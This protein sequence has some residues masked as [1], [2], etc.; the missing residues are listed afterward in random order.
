ML[1]ILPLEVQELIA[2]YC[3]QADAFRLA[4]TCRR[5]ARASV[6]R[7]YKA[8]VIDSRESYIDSAEIGH[9]TSKHTDK[10]VECNGPETLHSLKTVVRN[11]LALKRCVR[12]LKNT[13]NGM[14]T[15]VRHLECYKL[16]DMTSHEFK[17]HMSAMIPLLPKLQSLVWKCSPQ[18]SLPLMVTCNIGQ[19]MNSLTTI[20][21][22][23]PESLEACLDAMASKLEFP[24]LLHFELRSFTNP[25]NLTTVGRLL[26]RSPKLATLNLG[27]DMVVSRCLC[28]GNMTSSTRIHDHESQRKGALENFIN[29]YRDSAAG[30]KLE[31]CKFGIDGSVVHP[32]DADGLMDIL[33]LDA[34]KSL[35]LVNICE[36]PDDPDSLEIPRGASFLDKM[37]GKTPN[38]T[39]LHIDWSESGL[40]DTVPAYIA[41]FAQHGLESLNVKIRWTEYRIRAQKDEV[42]VTQ[43]QDAAITVSWEQTCRAYLSAIDENASS[44]RKLS[45]ESAEESRFADRAKIIPADILACIKQCR[46]LEGLRVLLKAMLLSDPSMLKDLHR[47]HYLDLFSDGGP[48]FLGQGS[49]V[50]DKRQDWL[51]YR[52]FVCDLL[53]NQPSLSFIKIESAY[54]FDLRSGDT[55]GVIGGADKWFADQVI[56]SWDT[57]TT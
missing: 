26:A 22:E 13:D 39:S 28:F 2:E 36:R 7:L 1:A 27:R 52:H 29:A 14:Y 51:R 15:L 10:T 33:V 30:K 50:G 32:K 44:L 31:L 49:F 4:L 57:V 56:D 41:S 34:L 8:I 20:S 48:S 19:C 12:S 45:L 42:H 17:K 6:P 11:A 16:P 18:V 25:E 43:S 37:A 38:V 5:L 21:L 54:L 47:L 9:I 23:I 35:S 53:D 24:N 3:Q 40:R 55:W 46:K